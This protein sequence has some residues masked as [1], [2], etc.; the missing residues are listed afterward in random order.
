MPFT[1]WVIYPDAAEKVT[2]TPECESFLVTVAKAALNIA[3]GNAPQRS[4]RYRES[5][6]A[7]GIEGSDKPQAALG[8]DV[9]YWHWVEFGT[10]NNEPYHVLEEAVRAV[11]EVYIP[12]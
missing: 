2:K 6:V 8:S 10:I 5:L 12:E 11:T 9:F 3:Y 1:K 4:G 7:A